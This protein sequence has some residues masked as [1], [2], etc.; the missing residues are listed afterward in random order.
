MTTP[1]Q[2]QQQFLQAMQVQQ[3]GQMLARK[4]LREILTDE[5]AAIF[6]QHG[7]V[8][9]PDRLRPGFF[10]RVFAMTCPT[11]NVMSVRQ[12]DLEAL[13][14]LCF[15]PIRRGNEPVLDL[16]IQQILVLRTDPRAAVRKAN[17]HW[18]SGNYTIEA[19]M[20]FSSPPWT[21]Q[22]DAWFDGE[23]PMET[24]PPRN[25]SGYGLRNEAELRGLR[26]HYVRR[27]AQVR[28]ARRASLVCAGVAAG[29]FLFTILRLLHLV[30]GWG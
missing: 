21:P 13:E 10:Y 23:N 4:L 22:T 1:E 19:W 6:L 28:F 11:Y 24:H 20:R 12:D 25:I 17:I 26:D 16:F 7:Y 9:V 15:A 2:R 18:I 30:L 8:D 14:V 29:A 5:Q 3:A 27:E